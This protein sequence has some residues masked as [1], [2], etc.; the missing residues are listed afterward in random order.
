MNGY[1]DVVGRGYPY[2]DIQGNAPQG[3]GYGG[4]PAYPDASMAMMAGAPPQDQMGFIGQPVN[5]LGNALGVP[6][7]QL[8]GSSCWPWVWGGWGGYPGPGPLG[9]PLG[10]GAAVIAGGPGQHAAMGRGPGQDGMGQPLGLGGPGLGWDPFCGVG[11]PVQPFVTQR[12]GEPARGLRPWVWTRFEDAFLGFDCV[13]IQPCSEETLCCTVD[14][15]VKI[16]KFVIPS[17]VAFQLLVT[18]IKVAREELLEC[19][20]VPAVMFAENTTMEKLFTFPTLQEGQTVCITLKNISDA[21]VEACVGAQI[22]RA[23]R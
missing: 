3:Y 21:A 20:A 23:V 10:P 22:V 16:Y 17:S 5:H 15:L 7:W 12:V 13:C 4:P 8:A 18:S 14:T 11:P 2:F 9:G 1:E 6:F 19:G